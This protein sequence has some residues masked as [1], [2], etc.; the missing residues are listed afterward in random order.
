MIR[1]KAL[2][3]SLHYHSKIIL[4][5]LTHKYSSHNFSFWLKQATAKVKQTR[6]AFHLSYV[7]QNDE[8]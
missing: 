1:N 2:I 8:K 3:L 7:K 6:F 5:T 4:S